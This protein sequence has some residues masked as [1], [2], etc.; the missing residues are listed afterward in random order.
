M[1]QPAYT[2]KKKTGSTPRKGELA[3]AE[4]APDQLRPTSRHDVFSYEG[5]ASEASWQYMTKEGGDVT[6]GAGLP[7][8]LDVF[9]LEPEREE[10]H[11]RLWGSYP[12]AHKVKVVGTGP[13]AGFVGYY[14]RLG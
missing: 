13:R 1:N 9:Y 2:T 4:V 6:G 14:R 10:M 5:A 11:D 3:V 8:K 7:L 12:L